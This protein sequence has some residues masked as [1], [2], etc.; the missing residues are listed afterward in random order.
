MYQTFK[1]IILSTTFKLKLDQTH[2]TSFNFGSMSCL[3]EKV[4][5]KIIDY[6]IK[7]MG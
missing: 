7:V 4:H 3:V 2:G 5:E 1:R 6:I